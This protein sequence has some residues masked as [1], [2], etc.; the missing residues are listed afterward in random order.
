MFENKLAQSVQHDYRHAA[1]N[2]RLAK[3]NRSPSRRITLTHSFVVISSAIV[4]TLL[5]L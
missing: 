5:M 4:I 3:E 2:Y 1:D